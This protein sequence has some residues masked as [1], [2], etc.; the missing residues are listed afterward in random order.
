MKKVLV[1]AL[2]VLS[3]F[4]FISCD[5]SG[6]AAT[7]GAEMEA[8]GGKY[9][10]QLYVEVV[11][12][13]SLEYFYD[14]KEGMRIVGE[15]L[16]VKTEYV[17]PADYDMNAVSAA[18]EQA[19]GAPGHGTDP[20]IRP[21]ADARFGD[22]QS[23]V[24]MGLAKRLGS[25]PREVAQ[26]I[27]EYREAHGPFKTPEDLLQVKGVGPKI[28]ELNKDRISVGGEARAKKSG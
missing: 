15:D 19:Y 12:L 24:A 28:L 16:G 7:A 26:K 10:D 2:L 27:V 23:N 17:G 5:K 20:M 4:T 1:L 8:E 14:H 6:D 13:A 25:K 18:I 11:A 9:S 22:Y 21:S 3:V